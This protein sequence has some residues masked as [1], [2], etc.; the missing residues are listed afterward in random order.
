M[1]RGV[2]SHGLPRGVVPETA[3]YALGV[4]RN[5]RGK[6][7]L[8]NFSSTPA[9]DVHLNVSYHFLVSYLL[10]QLRATALE[11]RPTVHTDLETW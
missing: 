3:F 9:L 4:P 2:G 8:D 6:G 1:A 11:D 5:C 10:L 7:F